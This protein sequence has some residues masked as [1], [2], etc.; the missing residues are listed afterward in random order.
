MTG[1]TREFWILVINDGARFE[2][3]PNWMNL[4][5]KG[6]IAAAFGGNALFRKMR[7]TVGGKIEDITEEVLREAERLRKKK[8]ARKKCKRG[9]Q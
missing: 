1:A 8:V 6:E 5:V 2:A 7:Y 4:F 9:A 3:D